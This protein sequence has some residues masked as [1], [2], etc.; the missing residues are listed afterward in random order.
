MNL[1]SLHWVFKIGTLAAVLF[2]SGLSPSVAQNVVTPQHIAEMETVETSL[3]SPDGQHIAYTVSKPADP[4]LENSTNSDHLYVLNV[5]EGTTTPY[6]TSS[7]VSF[8]QYRPGQNAI[9][10]LTKRPNDETRSIY[11]ISIN[12]GEAAKVFSFNQDIVSYSWSNNGNQLAFTANEAVEESSLPLPYQVDVYEE[13]KANQRGYIANVAMSSRSARPVSVEGSVYLME[14]SPA[15]DRIAVSAAPTPDVDDQY[16]RQ[17]IFVIEARTGE[18]TAEINNEGKLD[19]IEWSPN[20]QRLVLVAGSNIN[21]PIAG[22]MLI[23]SSRGGVPQIVDREFEGAYEQVKWTEDNFIHF[24]ASESTASRLGRI[25]FDGGEKLTLFYSDEHEISS[26]SISDSSSY[27]FV[28]SSSSH[29]AEVFYFSGEENDMYQRMTYHN[30]WLNSV[31]LGEQVKVSYQSRDGRY[32]I[33]GILIYPVGHQDNES[34][35]LIVHAHGGPESHYNNGWLTNY[36]MP[37]QVA[38]GKGY[39]VFYPN[40]RG[41]TGRGIDFAFSSQADLAGGEFDDIVDGVDYLIEIGLA[42]PAR[43]GITGKSYGGYA[44]AWMSTYYSSRFAAA[45]MYVGISNNI[46]KWGE[47]DIPEELYLVHARKRLWSDWDWFLRRSPIYH[48]ENAETPILIIHG[49]EDTRVHPSQSLELYR[50]LK[51]RKPNLPARL[52]NYPGE[53]H[54]ISRSSA[55]LDY[56]YRMFRWFDTYLKSGNASAEIPHWDSPVPDQN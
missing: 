10:F 26:F 15:G 33:D 16:M 3:L 22:R 1:I 42:D 7:S 52:V 51:V 41:S 14:W 2:F 34:A 54:T 46:S 53:G 20:G 38:A 17:Q 45:V 21:D 11:Q 13:N 9:T 30:E 47:S 56:T 43:V 27:S 12:G 32:S 6:Y 24:L 36:Y 49:A 28:A 18:V 25:R 37:G 44:T 23:A 29:P 55:K 8:V 4:Y 5:T 39:A 50:H 48:A 40:Y 19:Q 35:P 31:E